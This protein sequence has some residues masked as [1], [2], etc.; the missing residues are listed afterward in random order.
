MSGGSYDYLYV[1]DASDLFVNPGELAAMA[2]RLST[3]GYADDAAADAHDLLAIVRTQK[4][5]VE[6][7]QS[8]LYGVFHAVEWWDSG[9]SGE[10]NV[11]AELAKYRGQDA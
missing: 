10:E 1:K 5:R 4:V 3:L 7:A 9:D 11:H 6:A 8:R 2:T